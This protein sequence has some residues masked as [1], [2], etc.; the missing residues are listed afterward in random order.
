MVCHILSTV[1]LAIK[2]VRRF[3]E[4]R[5]LAQ[6][7]IMY[8]VVIENLAWESYGSKTVKNPP[9]QSVIPIYIINMR[10]KSVLQSRLNGK[11]DFH[12]I[13]HSNIANIEEV[14]GYVNYQ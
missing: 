10:C 1:N 7:L 5:N 13:W 4:R 14:L 2:S 8:K 9:L 6:I 12:K 11:P 3:I